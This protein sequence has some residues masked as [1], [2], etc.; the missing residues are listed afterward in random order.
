M[1]RPTAPRRTKSLWGIVTPS[2]N[3]RP[4]AQAFEAAAKFPN[5]NI[6]VLLNRKGA[7]LLNRKGAN[8]NEYIRLADD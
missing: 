1:L 6:L 8:D 3:Q 4:V 5:R 2:I 7:V